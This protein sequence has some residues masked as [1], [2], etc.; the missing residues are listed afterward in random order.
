MKMKPMDCIPLYL[1]QFPVGP[2]EP[3]DTLVDEVV[4][5]PLLQ[6]GGQVQAG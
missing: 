6:V 2:L 3:G 1:R 4:D 5:V